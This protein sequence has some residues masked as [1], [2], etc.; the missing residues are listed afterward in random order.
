VAKILYKPIGIL[1]GVLAGL[2]AGKLFELIWGLVSDE[3]PADADDR[4][5]G[6][7]EVLISAGIQGAVFATVQALVRRSGAK[8]FERVTGIWPGGDPK[9]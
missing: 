1:V 7:P 3:Q 6:W 9:D 8:G 2:L 4:D 5:A